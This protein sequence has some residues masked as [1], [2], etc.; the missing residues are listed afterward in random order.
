MDKKIDPSRQASKIYNLMKD[1]YVDL[2]WDDHSDDAETDIFLK[3]IGPRGKILDAGCGPGNISR[4]FIIRDYEVVGIDLSSG[5]IKIAKE[6]VRKGKF[7]V[8]D[9]R[10]IKF[11][12]ET[13]NGVY[14][15]YS[16]EHVSNHDV[17]KVLSEYHRVLKKNGILF[18]AVKAGHGEVY[19]EE[20]LADN[21]LCFFNFFDD[22]WLK[23][24][25]IE[26]KFNI[27]QFIRKKPVTKGELPNDKLIYI[28]KAIKS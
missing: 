20:P 18:L 26:N 9:M 28:A 7:L 27:C 13:F 8:M 10:N 4:Y 12:T 16:L 3:L 23:A 14:S 11:P 15:A 5:L 21:K 25:L 1:K 17:P 2:F 6:R 22:E 24:Q 19:L